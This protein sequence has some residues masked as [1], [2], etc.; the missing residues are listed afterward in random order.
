MENFERPVVCISKCL[1]FE[2][3]RYNGTVI[4]D[5]LVEK[6]KDYTTFIT[7]CP[8]KEIGLGTPREALRIVKE[9]DEL[10]IIESKGGTDYTKEFSN[11]SS[12]FIHSLNG[13]DGFIL[14]SRSPSCGIKDV[15]IYSSAA[16]G[17]SSEKGNGLFGGS[18]V[19]NFPGIPIEDEG[20]LSNFKIRENFLTKLFL[21]TR[22]KRVKESCSIEK[23]AKFHNMNKL[24]LMTFNQKELK[25][26]GRITANHENKSPETLIDEY[27]L[28]LLH[29]ISKSARYT[30]NI[31]ALQHAIGHFSKYISEAERSFLLTSIEKY[32]SG[33][34][35][36]SAPLYLV[37]SYAV[38]FNLTYLLNQ[39]FFEPYPEALIEMRDSGKTLN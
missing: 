27:E 15:K 5:A 19:A 10:R 13:I 29:A 34:I 4:S 6:M 9:N 23:L 17:A 7:V 14:K 38:R 12:N 2:S 16:R 8:E 22:F 30:S 25:E 36:F 32:R 11:F 1:G 28:H 21:L 39:S 26:L 35:P 24:L 18:I 3:C 31:N 33:H 20:R 37:K